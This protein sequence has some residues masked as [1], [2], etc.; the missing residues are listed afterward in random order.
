VLEHSSNRHA[1]VSDAGRAAELR[2]WA[3]LKKI[4]HIKLSKMRAAVVILGVLLSGTLIV[5]SSATSIKPV[6]F[7]A[8]FSE[9]DVVAFVEIQAGDIEK[10]DTP[11]FKAKSELCFKGC[12][13]GESLYFGPFRGYEVGSEYLVF[14][15]RTPS[16]VTMHRK[17]TAEKCTDDFEADASYLK[18]M[19]AGYSIM[20]VI[21]SSLISGGD[22]AVKFQYYQII[23]PRSFEPVRLRDHDRA[24]LECLVSKSVVESYL[25]QLNDRK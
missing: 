5:N 1:F 20:P 13:N 21:Y 4:H 23:L 9:A 8:L 17:A 25:Q 6:E 3:P 10:Y 24:G 15:E 7:G 19:Y 2:R 22:Y 18:V 16:S 14:L 12:N 11:L